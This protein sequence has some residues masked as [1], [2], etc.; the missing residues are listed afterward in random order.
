MNLFTA[1][2][3][4]FQR[5]ITSVLIIIFRF[6]T[7]GSL[8]SVENVTLYIPL[9]LIQNN[10]NTDGS[11]KQTENKYTTLRQQLPRPP[12]LEVPSLGFDPVWP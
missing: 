3:W 4:N 8:I 2:K 5:G 1:I 7:V 6:L 10:R 12:P 11:R 9:A